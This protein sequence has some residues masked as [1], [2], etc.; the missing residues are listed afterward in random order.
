MKDFSMLSD[1]WQGLL[2][3]LGLLGWI[4]LVYDLLR[5]VQLGRKHLLLP[6]IL[7]LV[8]SF[9]HLQVMIM[10]AFLYP[11]YPLG[12]RL[13][14]GP[15]IIVCLALLA[16]AAGLVAYTIAEGMTDAAHRDE[17][18]ELWVYFR[19]YAQKYL[20]LAQRTAT[21]DRRMESRS[22]QSSSP[23]ILLE[24]WGLWRRCKAFLRR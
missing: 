5:C 11:F 7:L 6:S 2:C 18:G 8:I 4:L 15:V 13:K 1:L 10:N 12:I 9:L 17:E 14:S 3:L 24:Q 21:R 20:I 19:L 16:A 22:Q 23:I